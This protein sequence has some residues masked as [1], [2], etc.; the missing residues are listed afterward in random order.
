M[1]YIIKSLAMAPKKGVSNN[2]AG[3]TPG[4]PGAR[5]VPISVRLQPPVLAWVDSRAEAL[6]SDRSKVIND[7]LLAAMSLSGE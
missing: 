6:G 4:E 2:P 3:R 5:A 1:Y 7:R